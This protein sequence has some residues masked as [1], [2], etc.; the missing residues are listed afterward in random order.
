MV[1]DETAA[2]VVERRDGNAV[3]SQHTAQPEWGWVSQ[4]SGCRGVPRMA[5]PPRSQAGTARVG[6]GLGLVTAPHQSI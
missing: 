3:R 6:P 2:E 5:A 1:A 4:H